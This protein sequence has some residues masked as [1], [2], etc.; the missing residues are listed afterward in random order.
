MVSGAAGFKRPIA[1]RSVY[2]KFVNN[3][4]T[5]VGTSHSPLT[6]VHYVVQ[7]AVGSGVLKR[8]DWYMELLS[9][10]FGAAVAGLFAIVGLVL[11]KKGES[12]QIRQDRK[13]N[14][15]LDCVDLLQKYDILVDKLRNDYVVFVLNKQSY[16]RRR[17]TKLTT[18]FVYEAEK[19]TKMEPIIYL[20]GRPDTVQKLRAYFETADKW[21]CK[22]VEEEIVSLDDLT[23]MEREMHEL[24]SDLL[25]AFDKIFRED[26]SLY[27][28]LAVRYKQL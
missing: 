23:K 10:F 25:I 16:D 28:F 8:R 9:V 11:G 5:K 7:G 6:S 13:C 20:I 22:L 2:L 1:V 26:E 14:L 21:L 24:K 3:T 4:R 12:L 19:S 17:F 27:E 15:I 18:E